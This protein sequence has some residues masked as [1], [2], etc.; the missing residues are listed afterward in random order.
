[1]LTIFVILIAVGAPVL[2]P[3]QVLWI[4]EQTCQGWAGQGSVGWREE[5]PQDYCSSHH[6]FRST[7]ILNN[8]HEIG[9]YPSVHLKA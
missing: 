6:H 4:L 1:M 9:L 8:E 7:G 2:P 5:L 3:V